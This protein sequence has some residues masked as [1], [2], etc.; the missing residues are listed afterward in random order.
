MRPHLNQWLG[1]V[2]FWLLFQLHGK[3]K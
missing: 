2:H 3:F 1:T